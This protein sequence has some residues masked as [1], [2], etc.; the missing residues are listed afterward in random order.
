LDRTHDGFPSNITP[1][2]EETIEAAKGRWSG[3]EMGQL[4]AL[5]LAMHNDPKKRIQDYE[6]CNGP[7]GDES[8]FY[9]VR[10][11]EETRT[12]EF[13]IEESAHDHIVPEWTITQPDGPGHFW[14]RMD[15]DTETANVTYVDSVGDTWGLPDCVDDGVLDIEW[16]PILI[17]EP[18][19]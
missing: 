11:N 12:Y 4:V 19:R 6:P 14:W 3:A 10:W 13:G 17:E 15:G 8:Y 9:W 7:A 18:P 1:D 2:I 16:W 5:F